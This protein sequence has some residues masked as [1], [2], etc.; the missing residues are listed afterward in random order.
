[1]S[2]SGSQQPAGGE[3][4]RRDL[5]QT[6]A[7]ALT[8]AGLAASVSVGAPQVAQAASSGPAWEQV[9]DLPMGATLYDI[10]FDSSDPNHGYIVGSKGTFLETTDAGKTW[11]PRSFLDLD[12][13]EEVTYR[14]EKVSFKDGEGW[15]IGKP[16]ILLHTADAGK[17]WERIPLS[18]KLPGEPSTVFATGPG[19]CGHACVCACVRACVRALSTDQGQGLG[20]VCGAEWVHGGPRPTD[21]IDI[22]DFG[23]PTQTKNQTNPLHC[24]PGSAEMTTSTGAV[25]K[26]TNAGRNWKAQVKETIDAT[27]NR[28]SSSGVKGA[29]YFTGSV[30]SVVRDQATGAYLAVS[31][32]GN[33]FL[34]WQPGQDFWVPHNRGTSRRIQNMGFIKVPLCVFFVQGKRVGGGRAE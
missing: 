2:M 17:S 7:A 10:D 12:P 3:T 33:F 29:S 15:I 32:R 4:S 18:P 25:Y 34:T 6:S 1:M 24:N 11:V 30:I 31:S 13:D 21:L 19:E 9:T 5:L 22:T 28:I 8:A 20:C 23:D 27:L 16:P 26:T 14:F